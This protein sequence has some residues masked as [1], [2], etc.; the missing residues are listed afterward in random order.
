[1][2]NKFLIFT[3]ALS[4]L[5]SSTE[6]QTADSLYNLQKCIDYA[7]KNNKELLNADIDTKISEQKVNET[8]AIGYPK[9]MASGSAVN[10][11][12]LPRMFLPNNPGPFYNPAAGKL[13]VLE[14]FFQVKN[15]GDLNAQLTQLIF[16][17]SY[18]VGLQAASTYTELS[19]QSLTQ[20]KIKTVE[21]VSKAYFAIL[22]SIESDKVFEANL[23]RLD[24][25]LN[26]LKISAKTGLIE[27]I[28]VQRVEVQYNNLLTDRQNSKNRTQLA[29][30]ILKLNMGMNVD[31]PIHLTDSISA[32]NITPEPLVAEQFNPTQRI[33][34]S[35]IQTQERLTL[36]DLKRLKYSRLP[37][38]AAF[39]KYGFVRGNLKFHELFQYQWY[40]YSMVGLNLSFPILDFTRHYQIK[41]A[42]YTSQKVKN[43]KENLENAFKVEASSSRLI[44]NNS[45]KTMENQ[46]RNMEMA[47]EV[48]RVTKI[49]YKEGV[50]SNLDLTNAEADLQNSQTNYY[51]ALY[52][53]M[54]AKIAYEKSIGKLY[55]E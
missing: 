32:Y 30:L 8:R 6:A 53:A 38:L 39:G 28:D 36:L 23:K 12:Q 43:S 16:D 25:T 51:S 5:W 17:G 37:T 55:T 4:L 19:R 44:F 14:N 9:I 22:I 20:A 18:V 21:E 42:S 24:S 26:E 13:S 7:L 10:N 15:S 47:K 3:T 48:V 1:M 40:S 45:I 27:E 34:Y 35:L 11:P 29:K 46:K 31:D 54:V 2:I 52:D 50:G 49:K 41:Q 33:E